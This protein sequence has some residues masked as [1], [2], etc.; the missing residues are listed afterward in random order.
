MKINLQYSNEFDNLKEI[1]CKR[2]ESAGGE[3]GIGISGEKSFHFVTPPKFCGLKLWGYIDFL[4][5]YCRF[6]LVRD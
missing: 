4:T 3:T 5:T 2:I 1:A 6:H